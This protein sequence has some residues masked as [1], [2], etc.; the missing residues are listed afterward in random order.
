MSSSLQLPIELS[1]LPVWALPAIG[2]GCAVFIL[3]LGYLLFGRRQPTE[4][5]PSWQD[6]KPLV[7]N[8][9]RSIQRANEAPR[10]ADQR[11]SMRRTGNPIDVQIT[12]SENKTPPISAIVIDRSLR[13][14]CLA[15]EFPERVGSVINVRPM[16]G[17]PSLPW[18]R[19]KVKNC[20]NVGKAYELGCEF[21]QV[22]PSSILMLFG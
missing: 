16:A 6:G 13:G 15:V 2:G 17:G 14:L 1:Q 7:R 19:L 21:L 10:G 18:I 22:P 12:D 3:F 11:S 4:R 5:P 9:E 20:R 8:Y